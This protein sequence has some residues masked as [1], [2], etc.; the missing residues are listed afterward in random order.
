[1]TC[2]APRM[3]DIQGFRLHHPHTSRQYYGC[4]AGA[5]RVTHGLVGAWE[6]FLRTQFSAGAGHPTSNLHLRVALWVKVPPSLA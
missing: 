1:M 4:M 6:L 5:G 3:A 2:M